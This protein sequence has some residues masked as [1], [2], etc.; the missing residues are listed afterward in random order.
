MHYLFLWNI[1]TLR[2]LSVAERRRIIKSSIALFRR[3]KS[4][5]MQ[6]RYFIIAILALLPAIIIF[7]N[8]TL[9]FAFVMFLINS[10]ML[11]WFLAKSEAPF[12]RDIIETEFE[13]LA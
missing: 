6:G 7:V 5:D 2:E 13:S 3:E 10:A 12:I 8:F 11:E 4:V 1:P 9:T